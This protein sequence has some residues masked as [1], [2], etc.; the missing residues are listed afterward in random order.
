MN[1]FTTLVPIER[2]GS[3][4]QSLASCDAHSERRLQ[5]AHLP[6]RRST[7]ERTDRGVQTDHRLSLS[8]SEDRNLP[9][10][11]WGTYDAFPK[12]TIIPKGSSF[13]AKIGAK[14]GHFL[15]YEELKKMTEGVP[16]TRGLIV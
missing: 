7:G 1:N 3:L 8:E 2:T 15:E 6:R 12:G 16:N 13:G 9:I 4:R 5:R 14:V 10:Y 11:I